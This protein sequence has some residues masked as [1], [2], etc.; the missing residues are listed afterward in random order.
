MLV[1]AT[2]VVMPGREPMRGTLCVHASF[3]FCTD[4]P[5]SPEFDSPPPPTSLSVAS[6]AVFGSKEEWFMK[7]LIIMASSPTFVSGPK[8]LNNWHGR[9]VGWGV[10]V[11]QHFKKPKK[12]SP[13]C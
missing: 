8:T 1:Y 13:N 4:L 3:L 6:T 10:R 7:R 11:T 12:K 5:T 9:V 2:I